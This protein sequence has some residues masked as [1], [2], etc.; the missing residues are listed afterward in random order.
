MDTHDTN[1]QDI[2]SKKLRAGRRTYFFDVKSTR[3]DD[4]YLTITESKKH[5]NEDGSSHFKK[6]KIF[7]YKE[8][9]LDFKEILDEVTKFIV[10]EKGEEVISDYQA[11]EADLTES[12]EG[13]KD[14]ESPDTEFTSI[15]F[16]DI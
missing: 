3:A 9:F 8:D 13:S 5:T 10:A 4:Y 11:P 16:E 6:H 15:E 12:I 7:L 14:V 2:F 1:S